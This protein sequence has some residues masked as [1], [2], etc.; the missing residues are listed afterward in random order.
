MSR[1]FKQRFIDE[2]TALLQSVSVTPKPGRMLVSRPLHD[3]LIEIIAEVNRPRTDWHLVAALTGVKSYICGARPDDVTENHFWEVRS[4]DD[5]PSV[6]G[7]LDTLH[8]RAAM[9]SN[10][11]P[12][13]LSAFGRTGDG[14]GIQHGEV[15]TTASSSSP[16]L[17]LI[18]AERLQIEAAVVDDRR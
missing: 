18:A 15:D 4:G 8:F 13:G 7:V 10:V 1:S 14:V 11:L 2:V 12:S 9:R 16:T 6:Y 17:R 5:G 3:A